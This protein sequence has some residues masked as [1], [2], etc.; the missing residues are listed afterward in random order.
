MVSISNNCQ[1]WVHRGGIIFWGDM[2]G[3]KLIHQSL[4]KWEKMYGGFYKPSDYLAERAARGKLLVSTHTTI[5][6]TNEELNHC[7]YIN[8]IYSADPY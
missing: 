7:R 4:S 8:L 6:Y 3:P 2:I 5:I 1:F